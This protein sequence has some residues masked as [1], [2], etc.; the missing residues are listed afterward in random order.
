MS[1]TRRVGWV[2]LESLNFFFF[3]WFFVLL[4]F[5]FY[6]TATTEIYTLSLHDA[7]PISLRKIIEET[8]TW[9]F[10]SDFSDK[11]SHTYFWYYSEDKMEPRL[12]FRDNEA[13]AECEMP[14]AVARDVQRLYQCL[15]S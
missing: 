1:K 5:F 14:I 9:T 3:F 13:G 4:F 8:Y 10:E 15:S 7:L 11:A 12:G 2:A 6:D